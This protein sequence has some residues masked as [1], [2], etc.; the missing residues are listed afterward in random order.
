MTTEYRAV[1]DAEV[2]FSNK[3][4]LQ[5]QGFRVDL[6]GSDVTNEEIGELFVASLDLLMTQDVELHNVKIVEEEH[7]GTR[8]GPSD[9]NR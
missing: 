7:K 8:N 2:T 6:P 4:G 5:V 9:P 3:G 1:F